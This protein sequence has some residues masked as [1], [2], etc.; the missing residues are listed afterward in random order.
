MSDTEGLQ[1]GTEVQFKGTE[2]QFKGTVMMLTTCVDFW[3]VGLLLVCTT[4]LS[5]VGRIKFMIAN[6]CLC[7]PAG[8]IL[9]G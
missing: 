4:L 7:S 6:K 2:V 9:I 5:E 3:V 1:M 8:N